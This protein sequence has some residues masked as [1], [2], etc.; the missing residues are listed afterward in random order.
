MRRG[1]LWLLLFLLVCP[2][3]VQVFAVRI[4]PPTA[5]HA[6]H[7]DVD[8]SHR[9]GG[10]HGRRARRGLFVSVRVRTFM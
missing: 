6:T 1:S 5:V 8:F 4:P 7:V 2:C 3:P 9:T 10:A